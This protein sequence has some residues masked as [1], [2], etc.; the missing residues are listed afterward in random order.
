MHHLTAALAT[1]TLA[2]ALAPAVAAP[3]YAAGQDRAPSHSSPHA[4]AALEKVHGLLAGTLPQGSTTGAPDVTMALVK[5][6]GQRDHLAPRDRRQADALFAR[7]DQ[8]GSP[9]YSEDQDS[10]ADWDTS[11]VAAAKST[12]ADTTMW[13][14]NNFCVHWVPADALD[15]AGNASSQR[16][17]DA[18]VQATVDTL[19]TVWTTE[20]GT[21]AGQLGF[22]APKADGIR[23]GTGSTNKLD[24]YL[25][26]T[27]A[28]HNY[29]YAVPEQ[30]TDASFGYLVLDNDFSTKQFPSTTTTPDE[31]RQVTAAHEFFHLVQFAYDSYESPWLMEATATWMEEQVYDDIDDNRQFIPSGSLRH[32]SQPLDTFLANSGAQY[33]TWVFP[34]LISEQFGTDSIRDVWVSAGKTAGRN[35]R[36]ALDSALKLRG[37]SLR[38]EFLNFT[39]ASMAPSRF[40]E[41][42]SEGA[43]Y[44]PAAIMGKTWKLS[45]ATK[46]TGSWT[47]GVDHLAS[48]DFSVTP[49][50]SLTANWKM[51][52]TI[53][54]PADSGT[55]YAI[56]VYKDGHVGKAP[57]TLTDGKLVR[58]FPFSVGAVSR[59]SVALGNSSTANGRETHF[60]ATIW[61]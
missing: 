58:S 12:C 7:P 19:K 54:A 49:D 21:D 50:A 46:S 38:Q 22:L 35:P 24:V 9:T 3:A 59:I 2:V 45:T 33:G 10:N 30:S 39:G 42:W 56:V 23:G 4:L 14:V 1:T 55:A 13:G 61:R 16:S 29:G 53:A 57:L 5:L 17:T 8:P 51:R 25:A 28:A 15:A 41:F 36:S 32:R 6:M 34:E 11:E 52:L 26:D 44:Y 27:G 48:A 40:P 60:S 47:A 31:A 37:S 18:A 20:T 43:A